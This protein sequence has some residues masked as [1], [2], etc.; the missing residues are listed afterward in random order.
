MLH[1]CPPNSSNPHTIPTAF[2]VCSVRHRFCTE[3]AIFVRICHC[4]Y[5]KN[6]QTPQSCC[7]FCWLLCFT[8]STVLFSVFFSIVYF[9]PSHFCIRFC[10]RFV[11]AIWYSFLFPFTQKLCNPLFELVHSSLNLL[12]HAAQNTQTTPIHNKKPPSHHI[13]ITSSLRTIYPLIFK[14]STFFGYSSIFSLNLFKAQAP[15]QVVPEFLLPAYEF[16]VCAS[17][18]NRIIFVHHNT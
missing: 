17:D 4:V 7:P 15:L 12:F 18:H 13:Q 10:A 11:C 3:V 9:I 1:L 14:V 8:Y 16:S 6:I 2:L 5:V